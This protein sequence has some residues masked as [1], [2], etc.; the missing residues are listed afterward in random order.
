MAAVLK[1]VLAKS[2]KTKIN[3]LIDVTKILTMEVNHLK[4]YGLIAKPLESLEGGA[5][6]GL[7]LK[8]GKEGELVIY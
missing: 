8:K 3:I 1:T 2:Y 4:E 7:K 5:A 6:L